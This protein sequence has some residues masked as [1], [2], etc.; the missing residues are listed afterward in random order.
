MLDSF[1]N[2]C[3]RLQHPK[4]GRKRSQPV[5]LRVPD[6]L[7][8][9]LQLLGAYNALG[10]LLEG[11]ALPKTS[12]GLDE[13]SIQEVLL[14]RQLCKGKVA[15]GR[16]E[17]QERELVVEPDPLYQSLDRAPADRIN[18]SGPLA[19]RG[20]SRSR[21]SSPN[22]HHGVAMAV[23]GSFC[24]MVFGKR[25]MEWRVTLLTRRGVITDTFDRA[26]MMKSL[27]L[28][29]PEAVAMGSGCVARLRRRSGGG[30]SVVL[31]RFG[32]TRRWRS[33]HGRLRDTT[34]RR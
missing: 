20:C 33:S 22:L 25:K 5:G 9:G 12:A 29:T 8:E 18:R 32:V 13:G 23:G 34:Q 6:N 7:D 15:I 31:A 19:T 16:R 24:F 4:G 27:V 30:A 3:Y 11:M 1:V 26:L 17:Q 10:V 14:S 2:L 28:P 21:A